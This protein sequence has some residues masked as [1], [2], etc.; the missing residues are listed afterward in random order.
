MLPAYLARINTGLS[1]E[2][3][4]FRSEREKIYKLYSD[5]LEENL[6]RIAAEFPSRAQAIIDALIEELKD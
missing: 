3:A 5:V 6:P 4:R 1:K 2:D